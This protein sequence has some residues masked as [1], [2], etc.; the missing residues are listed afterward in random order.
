M[1]VM[2]AKLE[3]YRSYFVSNEHAHRDTNCSLPRFPTGIV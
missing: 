2:S 3:R 1:T